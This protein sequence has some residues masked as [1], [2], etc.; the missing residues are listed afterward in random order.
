MDMPVST[1][2]QQIVYPNRQRDIGHRFRIAHL[3]SKA[4]KELNGQVCTVVGFDQDPQARLHCRVGADDDKSGSGSGAGGGTVKRLKATNLVTLEA[5]VMENF[6]PESAPIQDDEIAVC[7]AHAIE[8][9]GAV[10]EKTDRL[11]LAHRVGLYK[12]LHAKLRNPSY[13]MQPSD[14]CFPC[15]A[16]GDL[17]GADNGFAVVMSLM[18]PPCVGNNEMDV[19]HAD[20]GLKGDGHSICSICSNVLDVESDEILVTLPCVH[21]FHEGC[22]VRWLDSDLGSA[23]WN[24]PECRAAVPDIM[25]TFRVN[26]QEQLQRRI[27]EFPLSGFCTKCM[28]WVMERNRNQPL[29]M[30]DG[31]GTLHV[32]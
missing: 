8:K 10:A 18:K 31:D 28:I 25:E 3:T 15:G 26:R 9:H 21:V 23:Q 32:G 11:D 13:T 5:A 7:L 14:Y 30:E 24:C 19:R 29:G 27:D 22:L 6:M 1:L 2:L 16:G 20:I 4:G 17:G 12:S